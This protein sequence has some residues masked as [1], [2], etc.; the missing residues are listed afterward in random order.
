MAGYIGRP[1]LTE[2]VFDEE[3]F[4]MTGDA[5]YLL[6]P[7]DPNKGLV[8]DGRL[9][10]NFKLQTG[11]WVAVGSVR[12]ALIDA[13]APF[14]QDAVVVGENRE[15]LGILVFP[16]LAH[17]RTL[18]GNEPSSDEQLLR[19][20]SVIKAI[21]N[22]IDAYSAM[23][24]ASSRRIRRAML[25]LEPPSLEA[26]ETTDKGYLNQR[27]VIV[28]RSELVECLYETDNAGVLYF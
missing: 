19:H 15:M 3:G 16:S 2:Q 25:M 6:D 28:R 14:I 27:A 12:L 17:C 9:T 18:A 22:G 11:N 7:D 10:E 5:A 24:S 8:Y 26:G 21:R 20:P 13:G 23:N 4:L 1:E